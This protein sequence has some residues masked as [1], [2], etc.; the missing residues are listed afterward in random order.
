MAAFF[1]W[2]QLSWAIIVE[3]GNF[4]QM[5]LTQIGAFPLFGAAVLFLRNIKCE[6]CKTI[7]LKTG[8]E[9]LEDAV[10]LLDLVRI[11]PSQWLTE[12]KCTTDKECRTCGLER[13]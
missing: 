1:T 8:H 4:G 12:L 13:Y 2:I 10:S 11:V 5:S 3:E 6:R 9:T 7:W